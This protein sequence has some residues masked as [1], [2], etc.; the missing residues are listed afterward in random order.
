MID[1]TGTFDA[2]YTQYNGCERGNK[3][4]HYSTWIKVGMCIWYKVDSVLIIYFCS[5][6]YNIRNHVYRF[7]Q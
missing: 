4:Y 5:N 2:I 3:I 6:H 7:C 1:F